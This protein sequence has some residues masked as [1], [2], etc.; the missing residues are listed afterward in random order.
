MNFSFENINRIESNSMRKRWRHNWGKI[1]MQRIQSFQ[2]I[3]P[4]WRFRILRKYLKSTIL[5][6]S[7]GVKVLRCRSLWGYGSES[8][9]ARG[10]WS[11]WI[12]NHSDMRSKPTRR[13]NAV[14]HGTTS[15]TLGT[16]SFLLTVLFHAYYRRPDR[17]SCQQA[18][19]WKMEVFDF[20]EF[21]KFCSCSSE[22]SMA[23]A[24]LN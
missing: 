24:V 17:L 12:H 16:L 19:R 6:Q 22:A 10:H 8:H 1:V 21:G 9:S 15:R 18:L 4:N 23:V 20:L 7:H 14:S 5:L 2:R 3:I 11:D 13:Q